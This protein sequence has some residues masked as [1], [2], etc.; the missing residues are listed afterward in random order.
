[1]SLILL[2][3]VDG[4]ILSS[5]ASSGKTGGPREALRPL[6]QLGKVGIAQPNT[7]AKLKQLN[8]AVLS[9]GGDFRVTECH[10]DISVQRTARAKYDRWVSAKKPR[11]G[12]PA[13][14][15]KTMKAA[16]VAT[17]GR[18]GHNAGVSIDIDIGSLKFP[19]VAADKRL[20]KLWEIATP[21]GW[22]PV[23]RTP[24]ERASESWHFDCWGELKG[25]RDRL[26]YEQAALCGAI[27]VG[28]GD[29]SGY[30]A[31]LQALLVRAGYDIGKIDGAIG[32]KTRAALATAVGTPDVDRL[33]VRK[34]RSVLERLLALPA[35]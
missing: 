21:I 13:F 11:P 19:G 3:P 31:E 26:G 32:A 27:L 22:S 14:D 12:T 18:S 4:T 9:A 30:D 29:L 33:I 23:I 7:A 10:R 2:V 5:Y 8:D 24:D 28:H 25:V 16:F 20:D 35:K 15:S 17:P 6:A 1:M 34:D